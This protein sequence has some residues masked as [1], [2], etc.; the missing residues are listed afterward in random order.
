MHRPKLGTI[1]MDKKA[2]KRFFVRWKLKREKTW[3][4]GMMFYSKKKDAEDNIRER[5]SWSHNKH[6]QFKIGTR[7]E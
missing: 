3:Y 4:D 7:E 6:W 5:K 1:H 2:M